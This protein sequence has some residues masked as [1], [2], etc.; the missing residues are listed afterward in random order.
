MNVTQAWMAGV[1]LI[2][3]VF[4]VFAIVGYVRAKR[5]GNVAFESDEM[6]G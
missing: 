3:G 1:V 6:G 4:A 2:M 5:R